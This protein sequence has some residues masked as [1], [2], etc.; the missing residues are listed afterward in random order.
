MFRL[1][2]TRSDACVCVITSPSAHCDNS[3]LGG[4]SDIDANMSVQTRFVADKVRI[5]TTGVVFYDNVSYLR[6][7]SCCFLQIPFS[8]SHL[9]PAPYSS[10]TSAYIL[11]LKR[12]TKFQAYQILILLEE[13]LLAQ[14]EYV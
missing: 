2:H 9:L 13:V 1:Q 3:K 6:S 10:L 5:I 8:S 4:D 11:S 7:S 12:E 14:Y